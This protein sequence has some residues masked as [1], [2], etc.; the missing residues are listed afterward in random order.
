MR[1][2]L[3]IP[4]PALP[5]LPLL[6]VAC[7][8]TVPAAGCAGPAEVQEISWE[9]DCSGCPEGL[10]LRFGRDGRALLTVTG[11]ARMRT[12]DREQPAALA[13]ADFERLA[14]ALADA[15]YFGLAAQHEDS[16]LADGRWTQWRAVCRDGTRE[17]LRRDGAG[18]PA[19]DAMDAVVEAWRRRLWPAS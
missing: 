15:G 14:R 17:I 19:L 11:K 2:T 9:H 12:A 7:A 3:V 5:L 18:P 10:R 8:G 16:S 13:P 6:G 1:C 4:W